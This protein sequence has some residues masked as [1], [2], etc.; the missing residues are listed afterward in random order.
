[1]T[2]VI[3][4]PDFAVVAFSTIICLSG[5]ISAVVELPIPVAELFAA[6]VELSVPVV[7]L[8]APVIKEKVVYVLSTIN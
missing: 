8:F 2:V 4:C 6:V 7:E 3:P 1:M 5:D